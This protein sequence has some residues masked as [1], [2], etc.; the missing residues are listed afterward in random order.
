MEGRGARGGALWAGSSARRDVRARWHGVRRLERARQDH[1]ASALELIRRSASPA[2]PQPASIRQKKE[3]R[4]SQR[5]SWEPQR[6]HDSTAVTAALGGCPPG[7][8][9]FRQRLVPLLDREPPEER[10][11]VER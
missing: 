8:L 7:R 5:K 10:L 2:G 6:S 11:L 4:R 3:T 9:A 1:P